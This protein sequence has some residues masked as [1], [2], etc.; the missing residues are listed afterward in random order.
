MNLQNKDLQEYIGLLLKW[1]WIL[2]LGALLGVGAGYIMSRSETPIYEAKVTLIIGNFVLES[3]NPNTG[4]LA[5]SQ[6]LAQSYAEIIKREPILRATVEALGA[7]INWISLKDKV[8]GRL[9]PNTQL[10]EVRVVDGD[11]LMVKRLADEL[12]RQLILQSPTTLNEEQQAQHDFVQTE[13][14]Q[15]QE[16]ITVLREQIRNEEAALDLEVTTEG[17]EKKLTEIEFL[18]TRLSALQNNYASLLTYSQENQVN[19]LSVIE[20]ATTPTGPINTNNPQRRAIQGGAIGLALALGIVF[21]I[22]YFDNTIKTTDDIE[23]ILNVPTLSAVGYSEA[24]NAANYTVVNQG[25][26]SP[27]AESYRILRTNLQFANPELSLHT[28]LVTSSVAGEGKSITAANLAI[29]MAQA[30]SG[31]FLIQDDQNCQPQ[32]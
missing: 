23:Q 30:D 16:S 24:V 19:Q 8:S 10:F 14:A 4:E 27:L 18:R 2:L 26:F 29:V 32:N 13:L 28:L 12:A 31:Y 9:V 20:P 6:T 17:I 11:P 5:T 22:E 15:L 25:V 3:R 21:L 1:W 7:D